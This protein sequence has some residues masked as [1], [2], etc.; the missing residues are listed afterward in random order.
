MMK[1]QVYRNSSAKSIEK[2]DAPRKERIMPDI[3]LKHVTVK[4]IDKTAAGQRIDNFLVGLLKGV[5]KTHIYQLLRS[6]QVRVNSRRKNVSYRLQM[7][8]KIRI[9]PVRLPQRTE[10][11]SSKCP[12]GN[13]DVLYQDEFLLV[14]NKPAGTAVHGG[15]GISFGV[16]EQLRARHSDW[17]F[18][19]LVHRLDRETSGVLLLA[20]KRSALVNLHEQIREGAVQRFYQVLVRG[21]WRNAVQNVRLPLIK[22]H[23]AAGERRVAVA[24]PNHRHKGREQDAHTRFILQHAW[25]DFSLLTAELETGR[26]HQIRVHLAHLGYPVAGDDKYG[27]FE[28][29]RQLIKRKQ[30]KALKRMFLHATQFVCTHPGTG[31]PLQIEAPLP[32]ELQAFLPPL[33]ANSEIS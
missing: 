22:Y 15:S 31:K 19:E 5:P 29:N 2:D 13:F 11:E 30:G 26:T 4:Q 17:R 33:G 25:R 6:G 23:T 14:I 20:R 28:L 3:M 21:K 24:T 9:P 16:I 27:D 32:D 1:K 7:D 12:P 10:K 18:L 8:D